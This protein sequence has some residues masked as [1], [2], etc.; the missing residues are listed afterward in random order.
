MEFNSLDNR[1]NYT[2]SETEV[3]ESD[4]QDCF[5]G[6]VEEGT[7][8]ATRRCVERNNWGK[9]DGNTCLTR[10]AYELRLLAAVS[11]SQL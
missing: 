11:A 6:A 5:Y 7:G 10:H 8:K 2:W 9:Y 1:G 3:G 4:E